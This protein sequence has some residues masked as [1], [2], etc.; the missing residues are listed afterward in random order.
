[1]HVTYTALDIL[2][3]PLHTSITID[4]LDFET[5]SVEEGLH[6][7]ITVKDFKA[8][9]IHAETLKTSVT[10]CYS[11]PTRPMQLNYCMNGMQC[12]YTLMTIGEYRGPSATPIPNSLKQV[13]TPPVKLQSVTQ[14]QPAAAIGD[15]KVAAMPPPSRPISRSKTR[16]PPASQ[17]VQRP[18]PPPPKASLD[19]ESL[20]L[21]QYDDEDRQWGENYNEEEDT[22]G[23]SASATNVW[24]SCFPTNPELTMGTRLGLSQ[25]SGANSR[26]QICSRTFRY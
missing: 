9:A 20:F 8:V 12:E 16:D 26:P 15:R 4:N 19:P 17:K 6:I 10:A 24:L 2:K 23:W 21:P 5:F 18:S 14:Q 13:A 1:M 25:T 7:G 3:Q 11:F 22:V